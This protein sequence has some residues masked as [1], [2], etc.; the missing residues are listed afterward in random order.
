MIGLRWLLRYLW[1][2]AAGAAARAVTA[3]GATSGAALGERK[4]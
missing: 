2:F 3:E 1:S 4:L